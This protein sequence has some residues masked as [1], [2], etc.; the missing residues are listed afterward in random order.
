MKI[1]ED[2][3]NSDG[4]HVGTTWQRR[5]WVCLV[6][7]I[8]PTLVALS[9]VLLRPQDRIQ[10]LQMKNADIAAFSPDGQLLAIPSSPVSVFIGNL[11][12]TGFNQIDLQRTD[13]L[14]LIRSIKTAPTSRIAFHPDGQTL[15]VVGEDGIIRLYRLADGLELRTFEGH[16]NDRRRVVFSPDGHFIAS[17]GSGKVV[18]VWRVSDGKLVKILP[19]Q[20][21]V[22]R[23]AYSP[24]GQ[25]LAAEAGDVV[26]WRLSDDREIR[27]FKEINVNALS[28]SPDGS[29]LAI[30]LSYSGPAALH[31]EVHVWNMQTN[32]AQ[33]M[34]NLYLGDFIHS[35]AFDPTG[36]FIAAGGGFA[37][38]SGGIF[39]DGDFWPVRKIAIWRMDD[40]QR[41]QTISSPHKDVTNLVFSPDSGTLISTGRDRNFEGNL[42]FWR[43][44]P[45]S[46]WWDWATPGS[47]IAVLVTQMLWMWY[48]R[49]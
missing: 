30:G 16:T 6:M 40:G 22:D 2:T 38:M 13:N 43:V 5:V 23:I 1:Q 21:K 29:F 3:L 12:L 27:R 11:E 46:N 33:P 4:R 47:F 10:A 35:I 24:D 19:T 31:G 41:I 48:R 39:G 44:L 32:D 36:Q 18:Q 49:R 8:L 37:S 45:Q 34:W 15:A 14:S 42:G 28:F 17:G 20:E 26:V 25:L 9:I 7:L